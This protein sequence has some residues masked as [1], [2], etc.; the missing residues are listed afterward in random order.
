[1]RRE[2]EALIRLE[3]ENIVRIVARGE[4]AGGLYLA[5]EYLEGVTL[6]ELVR[7]SG[8]LPSGAVAAIGRSAAA[9]L[10]HVHASGLVHRDIKCSNVMLL[11]EEQ[12]LGKRVR[13]IDFGTA[14]AAERGD[15]RLDR[16]VGSLPYLAPELLLNDASASPAT[17]IYGLGVVM[18]RLATGVL[19]FLGTTA[20]ELIDAF[21]RGAAP[22]IEKSSPDIPA[23]LSAVIERAMARESASRWPTAEDLEDALGGFPE[24]R[25]QIAFPETRAA[26]GATATFR[27]GVSPLSGTTTR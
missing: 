16:V 12:A 3:H 22:R 4:Q 23:E 24:A 10:S 11:K 9:A 7:S 15:R 25:I 19:P 18:Y 26:L 5:M 8:A 6:D 14:A 20:G 13:L 27:R 1:L 17:D 2:H 21:S